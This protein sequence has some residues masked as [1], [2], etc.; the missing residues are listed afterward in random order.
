MRIGKLHTVRF[1]SLSDVYWVTLLETEDRA[2]NVPN[3]WL[4]G[5]TI[6]DN[7][8]FVH[9]EGGNSTSW[10]VLVAA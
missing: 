2:V 9:P 3:T 5:S 4:D 8:R 10:H 1:E 7:G 6:D